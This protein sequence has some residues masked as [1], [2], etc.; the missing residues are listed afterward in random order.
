MVHRR[1]R[2][3]SRSRIETPAC[4]MPVPL[5]VVGRGFGRARGLKHT[6]VPQPEI[7]EQVGRGFG[8]ARGLKH[9]ILVTTVESDGVGRGF[10]RARGLKLARP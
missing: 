3:R 5:A 10:G 1:A 4:Q 7:R 2:L 8:R 9:S 6:R